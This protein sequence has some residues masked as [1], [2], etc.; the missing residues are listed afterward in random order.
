MK[1]FG[2]NKTV[3]FTCVL[4][5]WNMQKYYYSSHFG[6]SDLTFLK[7][8]KKLNLYIINIF[9]TRNTT[10][11]PYVEKKTALNILM[12]ELHWQMRAAL[13]RSEHL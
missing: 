2:D 11:I 1:L 4:F 7:K 5:D 8:R 9:M 13:N 3:T 10:V 12:D 6:I